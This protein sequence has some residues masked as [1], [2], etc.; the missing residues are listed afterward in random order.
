MAAPCALWQA[1]SFYPA[2]YSADFDMRFAVSQAATGRKTVSR[3]SGCEVA[4][5]AT[6]MVMDY[7]GHGDLGL[8]FL[9]VI[10]WAAVSAPLLLAI[11]KLLSSRSS[12]GGIAGM[13]AVTGGAVVSGV[14]ISWLY[15][16][17]WFDF[18]R[19]EMCQRLWGL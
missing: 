16:W 11:E 6:E 5:L 4:K 13:C 10:L 8:A 15:C 17:S 3:R 12:L 7:R 18:P 14:V 1:G 2:E 9:F 19:P